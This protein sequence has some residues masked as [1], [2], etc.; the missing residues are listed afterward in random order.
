MKQRLVES[1]TK[2]NAELKN[3]PEINEATIWSLANYLEADGWIKVH[4]KVGD[5]LY[6][7]W[8]V[9][10]RIVIAEFV[11]IAIISAIKD[12]YSI[13]YKKIGGTICYQTDISS[14]GKTVFLTREE[15]EQ[16]LVNYESS[17][18]DV[19]RKEDVGK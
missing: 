10:G 6:K 11:V 15:A 16:K 18:N 19:E 7:L 1:L 12:K 2:A 9:G 14:V 4:C 8:T 3:I 17:K 13:K 5:K